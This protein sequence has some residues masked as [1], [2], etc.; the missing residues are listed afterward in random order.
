[1]V[2]V[3]AGAL[4]CHSK[5]Q[6]LVRKINCAVVILMHVVLIF[7]MTIAMVMI[8]TAVM[9]MKTMMMKMWTAVAQKTIV[10]LQ[11]C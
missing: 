5:G 1:M 6:L 8:E 7:M 9:K 4:P 11:N 10:I 3:N 2:I